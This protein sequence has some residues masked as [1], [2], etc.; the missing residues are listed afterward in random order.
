MIGIFDSG[1]G[2]LSVVRQLLARDPSLDLLYFGD[3]AHS[4]YGNHSPE[5]IVGFCGSIYTY[6]QSRECQ[7]CIIACNTASAVAGDVLRAKALMP[8]F[9]VVSIGSK[10]ALSQSDS[11]VVGVM[12]TKGTVRSGA[13]EQHLRKGGA[14]EVYSYACPSLATLIEDPDID[15]DVLRMALKS[16][17]KDVRRDGI[18][19]LILGCTHYPLVKD[20][21]QEVVGSDVV[22]VDPAVGLSEEFFLYVA[23]NNLELGRNDSHLYYV[24]DF[25]DDFVQWVMVFMGKEIECEIL[26]L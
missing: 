5:R 21:I 3:S 6:L 8:V 11:G 13:Y 23:E 12:A 19:V 4:P 15:R 26:S 20:M 18:D 10:Y 7:A 2:G 25:G 24:S 14:R 1:I 9:D 17:L 22:L 16:Y